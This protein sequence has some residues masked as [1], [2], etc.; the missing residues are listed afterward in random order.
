MGCMAG[1]PSSSGSTVGPAL[2]RDW[3]PFHLENQW[4]QDVPFS[5]PTPAP[6]TEQLTS[7]LW[8]LRT[9]FGTAP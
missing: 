3:V 5:K 4:G 6:C 7:T 9:C 2:C 1:P 8:H